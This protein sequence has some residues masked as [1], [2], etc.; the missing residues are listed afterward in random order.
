VD[1]KTNNLSNVVTIQR[2]EDSINVRSLKPMSKRYL[3]Y[4]SKKYLKKHQIRDFLRVIASEKD[5]YKLSYFKLNEEE[6]Q[7]AEE[8]EETE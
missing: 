8:K 2:R 7:E 6:A 3:K 4:L 1:G 5:K